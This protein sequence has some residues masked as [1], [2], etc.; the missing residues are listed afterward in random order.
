[1][2]ASATRPQAKDFSDKERRSGCRT[3]GNPGQPHRKRAA[4]VDWE[5]RR[6]GGPHAGRGTRLGSNVPSAGINL[7]RDRLVDDGERLVVGVERH[8]SWG[9]VG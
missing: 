7:G 9:G 8:G 2:S 3:V 6:I 4:V 1:M 5:G